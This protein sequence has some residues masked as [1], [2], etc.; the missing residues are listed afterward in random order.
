MSIWTTITVCR[1]LRGDDSN[2]A[3]IAILV[4]RLWAALQRR[5]I[6]AWFPRAPSVRNPAELS[7]RAKRR[8]FPPTHKASFKSIPSLF[9]LVRAELRKLNLKPSMAP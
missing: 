2:T 5:H 7:T 8:P 1:L 9:R 3:D 6:S 4:G